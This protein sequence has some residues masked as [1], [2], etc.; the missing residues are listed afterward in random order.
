MIH[1]VN[2][3]S[4]HLRYPSPSAFVLD[5]AQ[6]YEAHLLRKCFVEVVR[7]VYALEHQ[8]QSVGTRPTTL[9]WFPKRSAL[10]RPL[11]MFRHRTTK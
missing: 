3:M 2:F 8:G 10:R 4:G 1:P 5:F 11:S 6:L 9:V 7:K